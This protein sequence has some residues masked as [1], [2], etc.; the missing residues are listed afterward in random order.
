[1]TASVDMQPEKLLVDCKVLSEKKCIHSIQGKLAYATEDNFASRVVAGYHP[2]AADIF[3]L[4]ASAAYALCDV[5]NDLNKKNLSLYFYDGYRPLRAV[6]DFGI[7]CHAEVLN[8]NELVCKQKYYP[9]ID[10]A[11][12]IPKEYLGYPFSRHNFGF[13]V[14]LGIIDLT[15]HQMLDMG[16]CFDFFDEISHLAAT[17]E[18]IGQDALDNR[19]VLLQVMQENNFLTFEYEFW[20]FDYQ[21][22]PIKEAMDIPI[23]PS[24]KGIGVR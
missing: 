16:A 23:T 8:N 7:W 5:Q 24:L 3:L 14:D 17:A 11:D 19:R 20:H 12:L 15:T 9:H 22:Q 1:M 6:E 21:H 18:T 13:A 2:D 10:K 4:E